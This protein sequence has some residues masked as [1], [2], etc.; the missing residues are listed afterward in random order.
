M[1]SRIL[2]HGTVPEAKQFAGSDNAAIQIVVAIVDL[3]GKQP[4]W[5]NR[6]VRP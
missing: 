5:L 3:E 6:N 2:L 1:G 4:A